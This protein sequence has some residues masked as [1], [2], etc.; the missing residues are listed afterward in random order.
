MLA[1]AVIILGLLKIWQS[2]SSNFTEP[3]HFSFDIPGKS[4]Q[5]LNWEYVVQVSPD[6]KTIVYTDKSGPSSIIYARDINK[7][8]SYPIRGTED[9][10]DPVFENNNWISFTSTTG[11]LK[12]VPLAGGVPDISGT[13]VTNGLS[14]RSNGEIVL[15]DTWPSGLTFQPGWNDKEQELT[16]IDPSKNEGTHMLPYVLPGDKAALFTIWSKDGTYDDSK[17]AVVNLKTKERKILNYNGVELHGTSPRFIQ[18]PWGDYLLW[19]RSGNLYAS[20]FDLSGLKVT[21]PETNILGGISVNASSGKAAYSVTDANNGTLV[22]M[23]GKLDTAK[24]YLVW[25]DKNGVEK[26]A[27]TNSGPYLEPMI[28]SNGKALIILTGPAY[29][30]GTINFEKNKVEPLFTHGDNTMPQIT[31]D[32]NNFVFVSNFE[33][34]KYYI[35][36]SRLD[37]IGGAKK[38]VAAGGGYPEMSNLSPDGKNILYSLDRDIRIKDITEKEP[39]HLLFKSD[40]KATSPTFSPDGKFIAYRSDEIGG[41]F[42]LFIRPFPIT[43]IKVQVSIDDGLYPQWSVDGS[44]IY[45]RDDDKIMAAKIQTSPELKVISRRIVCN[46]I[47]VSSGY[48]QR[49]F[50]VDPDGRVLMLKSAEDLSKPVQVNVVVNWFSELK[51]KLTGQD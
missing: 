49:D 16:K 19:S 3:V 38:I 36:I 27:L 2:P 13:H 41:N 45:Y 42:K 29:T 26:N 20:T 18:A 17:I 14:W 50:T 48:T 46:S 32:G 51:K 24:N 10:V 22:Y 9:G 47:R 1:V 39:P 21:G 33:D 4:N 35:Y 28:S 30:I 31:P 44:E 25:V 23:P 15:A 11:T 37:G 5:I 8:V 6:C 34:G 12:K 43:D 7:L 40:A